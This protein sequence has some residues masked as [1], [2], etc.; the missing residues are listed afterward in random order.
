[1]SVLRYAQAPVKNWVVVVLAFISLSGCN[2]APSRMADRTSES[3]QKSVETAKNVAGPDIDLNCVINHIQ[4]PPESF[5]YAF[6]A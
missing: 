1:M 6:K 5:H 3:P 2:S 4:N